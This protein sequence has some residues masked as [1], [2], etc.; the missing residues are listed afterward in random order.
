VERLAEHGYV[1][2][3]V[4]VLACQLGLP[5]PA[6]LALLA[7][8]ALARRGQLDFAPLFALALAATIF[9][10][11]VWYEAG[12]RRGAQIL[13]FVCR[14]SL[15]PDVC[16]SKTSGLFER[17]GAKAIV[18]AYY[19]PGLSVVAA[20]LAGTL[21]MPRLRFHAQNLLGAALWC[22]GFLLLGFAFGRQID[23]LLARVERLGVG[24]LALVAAV[25]ALWIAARLF[26]RRRLLRELRMAR[27]DA[28]ELKRLLDEQAAVFVVDLRHRVEFDAD[29]RTIPG[30]LHILPEELP[31]RHGR[32]RAIATWSSSA[33]DR[34]R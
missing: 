21:R 30:A 7:T 31:A 12:R 13:A 33:P 32:S 28:A 27:I 15:E 19:L 2:L 16:V 26:Q 4:I 11:T 34:T 8:G 24:A 5:I 10:Q 1:G 17:L 25:L 3:F 6:E 23:A 20:P 9:G 22:G 14:V 29:P 18:V